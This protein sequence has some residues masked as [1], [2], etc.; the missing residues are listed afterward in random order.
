[1]NTKVL[2]ATLAGGV[3]SFLLG[4]LVFG[5]LLDPYYRSMMTETGTAAQRTPENMIMWALAIS[6]LVY[7]LMLA[8]IY[9]RWANI[10]TFRAGAIAGAII[11]FLI[12][13]SFDLSMYGM[14][15]MWTGGAGLI[16]DPLVNGAVGAVVGG[17]VGWVLGYGN[18]S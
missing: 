12:V 5:I 2:L 16:V 6:N 17:V 13:L 18:K 3:A 7:A 10:S 8:V 14:F 9:T 15:T 11:S 4:W 1:M